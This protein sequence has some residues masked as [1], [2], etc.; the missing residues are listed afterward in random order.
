MKRRALVITRMPIDLSVL[1]AICPSESIL[2]KTVNPGMTGYDIG[3]AERSA[4]YAPGVK[5]VS[6]ETL[7]GSKS[8]IPSKR[9]NKKGK[10]SS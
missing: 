8:L 6:M 9:H 1:P 4:P 3:S 7:I 10:W 2:S 5:N